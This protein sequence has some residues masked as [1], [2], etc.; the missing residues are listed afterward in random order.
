M[1]TI[2]KNCTLLDG[3][4][5]MVPVAGMNVVI[6]DGIIEKVTAEEVAD[7]GKIIDL[8]GRYFMPGLINMHVHLPAGGKMKKKPVDNEKLIKIVLKNKF[9]RGVGI[10]LCKSFAKSELYS[11]VTTVR[12]VGGVS[13]FDTILRDRINSGKTL[14]P[15]ILA[16]NTAVGVPGG[17]MVGTV[18]VGCK[19]PEEAREAVRKLASEKVD[20]IK[21][22]ITGGVLDAKVKGEPGVLKMPAEFVRACC[23]EAHRLG[24]KV[25]AHVESPEGV[26]VAVYNGV[27]T[28]EHG[29]VMDEETAKKFEETG[30]SYICTLSP[31]LPLA[32][33]DREITHATEMVRYNSNVVLDGVI[34]G[35]KKALEHGVKVGLGTDTGCPFV[36]HY[37][38]WRELAYFVKL[39]GVSPEFALHTATLVNAEIAGIDKETGS[40]EVGKSADFIVADKNPL[41]DFRNLSEPYMVAIRGKIIKNPKIKK[42]A[43]CEKYLDEYMPE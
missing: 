23:D 33:F 15:R 5:N 10:A 40:I 14:G 30:A 31:A 4:E 36:T 2:L 18:A 7:E 8:G 22:M 39:V 41:D 1:K 3:R 16:A 9:T 25:A 24:L 26:K 27:D 34:N 13:D 28:I 6:S 32:K 19:T 37:D 29:A 35:T 11:G 43:D 38:M 20:L 42:Y 12:T 17:H 21:L